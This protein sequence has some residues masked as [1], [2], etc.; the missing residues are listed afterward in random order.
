MSSI[1]SVGGANNGAN[2][3]FADSSSTKSKSS[4]SYLFG[5]TSSILG[6]YSMIKSGGYKKLLNA[7][8]ATQKTDG[9]NEGTSTDSK[10]SLADVKADSVKLKKSLAELSKDSLYEKKT[11]KDG[12]A[13]Y[14]REAIADAVKN[15]VDAYNDYLDSSSKVD[16]TGILSR[17]LSIVKNTNA[18]NALLSKSGISIGNDN[19]LSL[20]EDTLKQADVNVLKSLFTGAGSL[21]DTISSKAFES[22]G[23]ANSAVFSIDHAATY[24]YN[25]AYAVFA[26]SNSW[27]NGLM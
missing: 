10:T 16:S 22:Y 23:L 14:D 13:D 11:D 9:K 17:S 1:F 2:M 15:F 6:D 18:N 25:G 3:F 8:Y 4:V 20:D 19:K 24:T 7:Y 26:D 12:K 5:E 21:G 27:F